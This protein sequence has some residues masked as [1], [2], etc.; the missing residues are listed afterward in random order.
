MVLRLEASKRVRFSMMRVH[1]WTSTSNG[2]PV[3]SPPAISEDTRLLRTQSIF[4]LHVW[5]SAF[6]TMLTVL[7]NS[8]GCLLM[9]WTVNACFSYGNPTQPLAA[10][11]YLAFVNAGVVWTNVFFCMLILCSQASVLMAQRFV[12]HPVEPAGFLRCLLRLGRRTWL[13]YIGVLLSEIAMCVI[14]DQ[15]PKHLQRFKLQSYTTMLGDLWY[16]AHLDMETRRIYREE[17]I[18]GA[19][20]REAQRLSSQKRTW[21]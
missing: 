21:G 14:A 12:T 19:R 8:I 17:T 7:R 1:A 6:V 5:R 20:A 13:S 16:V 4:S 11:S 10:Q 9:A 18:A 15:V 2:G 3:A